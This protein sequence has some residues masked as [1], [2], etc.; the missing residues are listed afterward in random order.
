MAL[1]LT[2]PERTRRV[3]SPDLEID[4][5]G[6]C[7]HPSPLATRLAREAIHYVGK[8]DRVLLDDRLSRVL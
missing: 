5:L 1:G 6:A 7:I 2:V 4:T 8:A 3:V